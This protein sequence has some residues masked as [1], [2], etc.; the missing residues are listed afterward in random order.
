MR[1]SGKK[2]KDDDEEFT[3]I[4]AALQKFF[5]LLLQADASIIIPPFYDIERSDKTAPDIFSK[6]QVSELD[7]L[8]A[9]KRYFARLSKINDK[10]FAYGNVII[11]HSSSFFEIMDKLRQIFNDLKFGLYPRASDHEDSAEVGWLLY[12]NK[13]Q[14]SQRLAQLL[15]SLVN[16]QVGV[17]WKP[18][19]TNDRFCKDPSP[20]SPTE[21]V[22]AMH[23][24]S[25]ATKAVMI[26]Q[27]LLKWYSSSSKSFPDGTK[28]RLAPPFQAITIFAHKSKYSALVA[29][30]ASISAKIGSATCYKLAANLILDRPAPDTQETLRSYLLSIPSKNFP[31][32]PMFHSV[33]MAFR[34]STGI[35]FSFHPEN[36]SHAHALIAGLLCYMREYANPWFMRF[37]SEQYKQQHATSK[38]NAEEFNVDTAEGLEIISMLEND[39]EWNLDNPDFSQA[40]CTTKHTP[41]IASDTYMS[42]YQDTDSVSTFRPVAVE[43]NPVQPSLSV[44]PKVVSS[45]PVVSV[46]P[47]DSM[48]RMSDVD[49]RMSSLEERFHVFNLDIQKWKTQAQQE[50]QQQ[51][52]SLQTIIDML[53]TG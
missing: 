4:K 7:S 33:D 51:S 22:S 35:T 17:K 19:R 28:M 48:S 14:D 32:T 49:S 10:G 6:F 23:I 13:F 24:E 8:V 16:E 43:L 1:I 53:L 12:S 44:T 30:Q 47:S 27:A 41:V 50:S 31:N 39:N 36:A 29:R 11:A 9:I 45:I 15:S 25:A 2:T 37:F 42:L 38:W 26:R 46:T 20:A 21:T 18:I 34:S 3:T 52:K 5:D 40:D